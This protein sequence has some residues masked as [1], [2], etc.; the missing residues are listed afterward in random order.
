MQVTTKLNLDYAWRTALFGIV[1]AGWGFWS[2]YDGLIAY[3]RFNQSHAHGTYAE[4]RDKAREEA[5]QDVEAAQTA[6]EQR[7]AVN[8]VWS[9][10]YRP[11]FLQRLQETAWWEGYE[12]SARTKEGAPRRGLE[13]VRQLEDDYHSVWDIRAQYFMAIV[14]L[15]LGLLALGSLGLSAS[16]RFSAD[17]TGLHGLADKPIAYD[18][19][20]AIDWSRW[21]RKGIARLTASVNGATRTFKLDEWRFRGVNDILKTVE[22]QRPELARP[23]EL[24]PTSAQSVPPTEDSPEKE[25]GAE[26]P[27]TSTPNT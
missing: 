25:P 7:E 10:K 15:P 3:P 6:Y 9:Q 18:A 4:L 26:F 2:L 8:S 17:E 16:R 24:K 14:C 22:E 5:A 12:S 19:I 13:A 1:F 21:Q 27:K 11:I 20:Q 23:E